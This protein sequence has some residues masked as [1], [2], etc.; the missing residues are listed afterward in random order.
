MSK[1]SSKNADVIFERSLSLLLWNSQTDANS[2]FKFNLLQL[3][4]HEFRNG[5]YSA[6]SYFFSKVLVEIPAQ[7]VIPTAYVIYFY[8]YTQQADF[9]IMWPSEG[10]QTADGERFKIYLRAN[11]FCGFIAQGLG[12]L[13]GIMC[14]DSIRRTILVSSGTILGLSF[15]SGFFKKRVVMTAGQEFVTTFSFLRYGLETMLLSIY[16]RKRCAPPKQ[17]FALESFGIKDED[18]W[19]N[20]L[21]FFRLMGI[22]WGLTFIILQLKASEWF[23]FKLI[24]AGFIGIY[25]LIEKLLCRVWQTCLCQAIF[26][27]IKQVLMKLAVKILKFVKCVGIIFIWYFVILGVF[28]YA[29]YIA[30]G[31]FFGAWT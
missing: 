22:T 25:E 29:I 1:K 16:G 21:G 10:N 15:F 28:P 26:K 14:V 12:F 4:L 8:I 17:S 11:Y 18:L 19:N 5:W 24:R 13:I 6:T 31:D 27:P 2:I 3:F 23:F 20:W 9:S 30:I 7:L